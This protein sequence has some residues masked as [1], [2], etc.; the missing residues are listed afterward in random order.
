MVDMRQIM[1]SGKIN[2][3]GKRQNNQ[4]KYEEI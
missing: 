4:Q 2:V 3:S 1:Y